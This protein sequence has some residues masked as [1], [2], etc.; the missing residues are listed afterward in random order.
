MPRH[1]GLHREWTDI[2]DN[3]SYVRFGSFAAL[4]DNISLMSAFPETGRSD[5]QKLGEN[6]VRFRP[7]AAT[8]IIVLVTYLLY[9]Q[10][11]SPGYSVCP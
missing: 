8:P 1:L 10:N 2:E 9:S 11:V 6:R 5:Q 3:N 4:P 7:R